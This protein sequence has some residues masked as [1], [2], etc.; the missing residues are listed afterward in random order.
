MDGRAPS[1]EEQ[2]KLPIVN[3][4]EMGQPNPAAAMKAIAQDTEYQQMFQK[5]YG[6]DPNYEDVGR[7]I[8]AFERTL[9]FLDAPLLI[10][11]RSKPRNCVTL[12][13]QRHTCTTALCRHC[14]T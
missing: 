4:I 14:G 2:A 8:A 7:A 10:S 11:A 5:A 3:P 6:R 13:S 1:L 12:V 9:V